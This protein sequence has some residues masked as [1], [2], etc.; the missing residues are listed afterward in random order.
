MGGDATLDT[1][2]RVRRLEKVALRLIEETGPRLEDTAPARLLESFAEEHRARLCRMEALA[3]GSPSGPPPDAETEEGQLVATR[4]AR[5][6]D[7]LLQR[8]LLAEQTVAAEY[9]KAAA[10]RAGGPLHDM[11]MAGRDQE[12][13][14]VAVLD[15]LLSERRSP[16]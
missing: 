6:D 12:L 7:Q 3:G 2:T 15:A 1:L 11:L 8:L 4:Q 9:A 16:G 10:E 13:A 5:G 14:H